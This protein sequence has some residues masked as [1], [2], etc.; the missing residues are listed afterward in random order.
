[1][2]NAALFYLRRHS[3]SV[4][5]MK[6]VL[7]RKAQRV[8]REKARVKKVDPEAS[9]PKPRRREKPVEPPVDASALIDALVAKLVEQGYLNDARLADQKASSLRRGGRSARMIRSKL[10]AKGLG[11]EVARISRPAADEDAVWV[12]ARKKRLGPFSTKPELRKERRLKDLASL[13]RAGFS[14][15]LAKKVVDATEVPE[16]SLAFEE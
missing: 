9:E 13:A 6:R 7:A 1:L 8:N 16:L 10:Q 4:Q 14:F 11:A 3:A 2:Q 15:A 5:Q 12:H